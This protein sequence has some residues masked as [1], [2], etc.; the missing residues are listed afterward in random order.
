MLADPTVI[1]E[2]A[3]AGEILIASILVLPVEV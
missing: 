3:E 1:A 2:G